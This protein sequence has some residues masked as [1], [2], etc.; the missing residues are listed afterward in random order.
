MTY[1]DDDAIDLLTRA[2]SIPSLTGREDALAE[3]LCREL[4]GA[5]I[6]AHRDEVGN[7]VATAGHGQRE[8]VF[9]GHMDTVPGEIPVALRDGRLYG[10]GAV[11]AK[12]PL[13]SAIVALMRA[14]QT[15]SVQVTVIGAVQEEG[16]SIGARHLVDRPAP[17]YLIVGE[18]SNWDALVLGYKG[19]QRFTVTLRR[20]SGHTAGP[21]ASSPELLVD[22]WNRLSAWCAEHSRDAIGEFDRL[23]PTLIRIASNDDG[24]TDVASLHIGL[25]LPL[26]VALDEVR[27]T[28][29][30]FLPEAE[31][32]FAPGECAVRGGKGN[33]LVNLFRK[34]VREEDGEPRFKVKT[35][36]SDMN[37]V[38]PVWNCPM[39]AYGPGDSRLDHT[40]EEHV[41][42]DEYLR[43]VRVLTRVFEELQ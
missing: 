26:G 43:A 37:V 36:T 13:V 22:F 8:V 39:L 20:P 18:P 27:E 6:A 41:P 38:G 21:E 1:S 28:V 12:G 17:D 3:M 7:L 25:R 32:E 42:L 30:T 5:G 29:R 33:R 14:A 35:G 24:L 4:R 16:P 15:A 2:L 40:P 9:L 34:A 10:R 11:D 31:F 19:S 23:T